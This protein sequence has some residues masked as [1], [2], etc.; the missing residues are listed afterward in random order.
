MN[1]TPQK[2][3][4]RKHL[5]ESH[6]SKDCKK[7][8]EVLGKSQTYKKARNIVQHFLD[9]SSEIKEVTGTNLLK[10]DVIQ[11]IIEK[12]DTLSEDDLYDMIKE[13]NVTDNQ[14]IKIC[15]IMKTK[16]GKSICP[17]Q[18]KKKMRDRKKLIDSCFYLVKVEFEDKK[19]IDLKKMF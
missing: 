4:F 8:K 12:S 10:D 15:K 5:K 3:H 16:C 18:L 11:N 13:S 6:S 2:Y 9:A 1:Q 19:E 7:G 14:M 17:S